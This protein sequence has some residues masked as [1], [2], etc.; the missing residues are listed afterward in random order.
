[1][2]NDKYVETDSHLRLCNHFLTW[3]IIIITITI[4]IAGISIRVIC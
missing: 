2:E 3:F 1:M 4:F